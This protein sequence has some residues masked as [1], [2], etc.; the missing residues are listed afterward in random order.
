MKRQELTSRASKASS[1][2]FLIPPQ[3]RA[4]TYTREKKK[5]STVGW[6]GAPTALPTGL[7]QRASC[8]ASGAL[9][10]QGDMALK[11]APRCSDPQARV[12]WEEELGRVHLLRWTGRPSGSKGDWEGAWEA[13]GP[14]SLWGRLLLCLLLAGH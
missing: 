12:G 3:K 4:V 9:H 14:V 7:Y 5:L 1:V 13:T 8:S 6:E 11:D 2:P 10:S